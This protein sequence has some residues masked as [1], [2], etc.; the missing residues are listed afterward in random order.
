M[1]VPGRK[2]KIT[3]SHEDAGDQ[4]RTLISGL[5]TV[6]AQKSL[7]PLRTTSWSHA[8]TAALVDR[9]DDRAHGAVSPC[10]G[11]PATRE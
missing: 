7:A 6:A 4:L 9:I 8:I 11:P 2:K 3:M 5:K 1:H 10:F